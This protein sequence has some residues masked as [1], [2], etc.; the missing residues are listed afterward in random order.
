MTYYASGNPVLIHESEH[1]ALAL[2]PAIC[3]SKDVRVLRQKLL[4]QAGWNSVHRN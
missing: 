3:S 1:C 2:L 4:L